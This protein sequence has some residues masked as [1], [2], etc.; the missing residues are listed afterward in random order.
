MRHVHQS[1]EFFI[2][3]IATSNVFQLPGSTNSISFQSQPDV[4]RNKLKIY[5]WNA[6]GI[7]PKCLELRDLLINSE[8][9]QFFGY[10]GVEL[11]KADNSSFVA[12]YVTVRKDWNNI[13]GGRLLIFIRTDIVFENVIFME[14]LSIRLKAT[15]STWL[16]LCN[17]F[18]PNTTTQQNSFDPS[19]IKPSLTSIILGDFNGHSQLLNLFQP[20]NSYGDKIL[21]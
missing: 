9:Y 3:Q 15:K 1:P 17:V 13:F 14:V 7:R 16:E 20:P 5:Q 6:D 19:L 8:I 2:L 4:S 10:P 21:D 12:G 18:L 11:Q